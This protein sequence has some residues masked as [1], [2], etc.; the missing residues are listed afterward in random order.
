MDLNESELD[1]SGLYMSEMRY[2]ETGKVFYA[3]LFP[4]CFVY[5][6]GQLKITIFVGINVTEIRQ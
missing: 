4:H 6:I 3:C 5:K 1:E 2:I